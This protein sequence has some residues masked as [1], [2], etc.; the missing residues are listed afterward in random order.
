MIIT[1]LIGTTSITAFAADDID[2]SFYR[3]SS[4]AAECFS[5]KLAP[6]TNKPAGT[7]KAN[8]NDQDK[9]TVVLQ[10]G[11]SQEAL[12]SGNG[13]NAAGNYLAFAESQSDGGWIGG[14]ILS[15][16]SSSS[17]TY[18]YDIFDKVTLAGSGDSSK[19]FLRYCAYGSMLETIGI[20]KTSTEG[21]NFLR[22]IAGGLMILAYSVALFVD[23]VFIF[24]IKILKFL[25]PFQLFSLVQVSRLGYQDAGMFNNGGKWVIG[26]DDWIYPVASAVSE[27]YERIH[28]FAWVAIVP[29]FFALAIF[30][31]VIVINRGQ[32]RYMGQP[33][34]MYDIFK[35]LFIRLLFLVAGVPLLGATYSAALDGIENALSGDQRGSFITKVVGSTFVDFESWA[36]NTNLVPPSTLSTGEFTTSVVKDSAGHVS[37][38]PTNAAYSSLRSTCLE[39]NKT[40]GIFG[41]SF[42][43]ISVD[44]NTDLNS[45][46]NLTY[47]TTPNTYVSGLA[48][49]TGGD[50]D[51]KTNSRSVSESEVIY[52]LLNRYT[53][54]YF[55]HASDYE[56][57]CK[58]S[59]VASSDDSEGWKKWFEYLGKGWD[60]WDDFKPFNGEDDMSADAAKRVLFSGGLYGSEQPS[61][62]GYSYGAAGHDYIY[63]GTSDTN[64]GLSDLSMYNY[65][66]SDFAASSLKCYSNLKSS[67]GFVRRSHFSVNLI[68]SGMLPALYWFNAMTMLICYTVIGIGYAFA[69]LVN[70]VM[71]TVRSITSL[72]FA[73]LGSI[74][75]IAQSI[76]YVLIMILEVV[77]T[78]FA[79]ALVSDFLFAITGMIEGL[80]TTAVNAIFG[81]ITVSDGSMLSVGTATPVV[82]ALVLIVQII[83]V[84]W[85]TAKAMKVRK[86]IVKSVD[87]AAGGLI[88]R[89]I[90]A[91][92][93]G[94]AFAPHGAVGGGAA[95]LLRGA[96]MG[97]AASAAQGRSGKGKGIHKGVLGGMPGIGVGSAGGTNGGAGG[98]GGAGGGIVSEGGFGGTNDVINTGGDTSIMSSMSGSSGG[99]DVMNTSAGANGA[100]AMGSSGGAG[101]AGGSGSPGVG[102]AA[103][104]ITNER[105]AEN[106][107]EQSD[108]SVGEKMSQMTSLTGQT[109][110]QRQQSKDIRE[111]ETEQN[112]RTAMGEGGGT[113]ATADVDY[114]K[115][116]AVGTI[117]AKKAAFEK[118]GQSAEQTAVGV[119]EAIAGAYTGQAGLVKDGAKNAGNGALGMKDAQAASKNASTSGAA[120]AMQQRE[121]EAQRA[122]SNNANYGGNSSSTSS[123]SSSSNTMV[124][125][126]STAVTNQGGTK[127]VQSASNVD[128]SSA[129]INEGN[130]TNSL[131]DES[132]T[133]MSAK[134]KVSAS[135]R[136]KTA[137]STAQGGKTI[138]TGSGGSKG[139]KAQNGGTPLRQKSKYSE[140]RTEQSKARRAVA[141]NHRAG[142]TPNGNPKGNAPSA[143]Q[144]K[145]QQAHGMQAR[146]SQARVAQS[147]GTQTKA[148]ANRAS[149]RARMNESPTNAMKSQRSRVPW[150]IL[151]PLQR[152]S[153]NSSGN[154]N[155]QQQNR[156]AQ[157]QNTNRVRNVSA[158]EN[159]GSSG[160]FTGNT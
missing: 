90:V 142:K 46:A 81:T 118:M 64:K 78:L 56:T 41:N 24:V 127:T 146:N 132:Q 100:S 5:R 101:G 124:N 58:A 45:D 89:L 67:S 76:T 77:I 14:W 140:T 7:L 29:I 44:K 143:M 125:G 112:I 111:A 87:E 113:T 135:K 55:Y 116:K 79:F 18:S 121:V 131:K 15:L 107:Q 50:A 103:S 60:Y 80:L 6:D 65:L 26:P 17:S 11:G 128:R 39:I 75:A 9:M 28:D 95:P 138:S 38:R 57:K 40:A 4:N 31:A 104:A 37:F 47:D 36:A 51:Y 160:N 114:D 27:L 94:S 148:N 70:N 151:H 144:S 136:V 97:G 154:A 123:S 110:E 53:Q 108:K 157:A 52:D 153:R 93:G 92:S 3:L 8:E 16:L 22:L 2:Y 82:I 74:P 109:R 20:D 62:S 96:A 102:Q 21:F 48:E 61:A 141:E 73:M 68:G 98:D 145:Q 106:N 72:P 115:N 130:T 147:S 119:G 155:S 35:K 105:Y 71:R 10:Y 133:N 156:N 122:E 83:F 33:T 134:S 88:D 84:I 30:S 54:S 66:S 139:A 86:A 59:Y 126:Q 129:K 117:E 137:G 34:G 49:K 158:A 19:T 120:Q 159:R 69:M 23:S 152:Q 150:Q 32:R 12:N 85:F 43:N 149:R 63:Y 25:N 13:I 1:V 42:S 91:N 99:T